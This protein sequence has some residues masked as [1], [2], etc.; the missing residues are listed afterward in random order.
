MLNTI[1]TELRNKKTSRARFRA[2][3]GKL[4]S[5][6]AARTLSSV[7][8]EPTIVQTPF[9]ETQGAKLYGR[10][11][12]VPIL[13]SG[14]A[15]LPTFLSYFEDAAV[16]FIGLKRDEKTAVAH[17]YYRNL[18]KIGSTDTVI[19]LDPM[20]ATGGSSVAAV[21]IL[22][23]CGAKEENI[24]GAYVVAA[25]EGVKNLTKHFPKM[26]QVIL[27]T[28]KGLN[29]KKYIVPGIGDFGDRFYGTD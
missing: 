9:A 12:L 1:F 29:A 4:A 27:A 10:V 23:E 14:V 18:P 24:V 6:L 25:P 19:I 21:T 13:R 26:R 11:L 8:E 17:E 2:A 22:L 15:I 7:R 3:A 16:G 20:L 28:D 5:I